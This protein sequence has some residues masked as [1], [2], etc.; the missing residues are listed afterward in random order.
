MFCE[1]GQYQC[2]IKLGRFSSQVERRCPN[3]VV[4]HS[5]VE[6]TTEGHRDEFAA[7]TTN[8]SMTTVAPRPAPRKSLSQQVTSLLQSNRAESDE[9]EAVSVRAR[10]SKFR[11]LL[12]KNHQEPIILMH[13]TLTSTRHLNS[14]NPLRTGTH[15]NKPEDSPVMQAGA[16]SESS[17][18]CD[19]GDSNE[20][21]QDRPKPGRLDLRQFDNIT[22]AIG[23]LKVQ[24]S[25]SGAAKSSVQSSNKTTDT[26]AHPKPRRINNPR[27]KHGRAVAPP[28]LPL[29]LMFKGPTDRF[30]SA[31]V[32]DEQE[33][34]PLRRDEDENAIDFN[35]SPI[36]SRLLKNSKNHKV[37]ELN[38]PYESDCDS[39]QKISSSI[40]APKDS[41]KG[42]P[43]FSRNASVDSKDFINSRGAAIKQ[44]N[45]ILANKQPP[46]RLR[47]P[48]QS[49]S[50]DQSL[51]QDNPMPDTG[52]K[53][54]KDI[55]KDKKKIRSDEKSEKRKLKEE[56][57]IRR[58][59]EEKQRRQE[60]KLASKKSKSGACPNSVFSDGIPLFV[61]RCIEFIE[62]E[63]L[64]AEG[65][66]RVPG[67]RAHVETFV[68]KFKENPEMS[69]VEA[70][71]PVNAVATALKDFLKKL[72]PIVPLDLMNKLTELSNISERDRRVEAIREL[73]KKL[74]P[75]NH[76]L[77]KYVFAHFVRV[78][79]NHTLNSMDSKNLAICWWPTLLP[80]E[81]PDMTMF[82]QM[83]PHLEESVQTMIDQFDFI[84]DDE[85]Q[86]APA[87]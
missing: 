87:T 39:T 61:K 53:S 34:K 81:F 79:L 25:P 66:Y 73:V 24:Q 59:E 69:I 64:D 48:S 35:Q 72:G 44:L 49:L 5:Y 26:A 11:Q 58:Q 27:Q 43:G 18:D 36:A 42:R 20:N 47:D 54:D 10:V 50:H 3:T 75:N 84:F 4:L 13:S 68:Q 78:S 71:I 2:T 38:S 55:K 16:A 45:E 70:D 6:T 76:K 86:D 15:C 23:K 17:S 21:K 37:S 14:N 57:R 74:P 82:E 41:E 9:E 12:A 85:E 29:N 77:L 80:F 65:I 32:T 46:R 33:A 51:K 83:R 62:Y 30:A 56:E 60:K 63:G 1:S 7:L 52:K 8:A 31:G 22:T 40:N 28:K 19:T 67:N